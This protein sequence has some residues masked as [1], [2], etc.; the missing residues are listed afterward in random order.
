MT[1]K[2]FYCDDELEYRDYGIFDLSKADKT[3]KDFWNE[4]EECYELWKFD[5]YLVDETNAMLTGENV[6]ECLNHLH[7][8]NIQ[9]KHCLKKIEKELREYNE[10]IWNNEVKEMYPLKEEGK[11]YRS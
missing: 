1:E 10:L 9:L 2:R 5:N 11:Q 7:E 8:E 4:D 3:K 6:V